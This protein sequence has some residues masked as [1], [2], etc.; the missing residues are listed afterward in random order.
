M[1]QRPDHAPKH[2][3]VHI[4]A[5]DQSTATRQLDL[6]P[7]RNRHAAAGNCRLRRRSSWQRI[8]RND[9][10]HERRRRAGRLVSSPVPAPPGEQQ[11]RINVMAS[12]YNRHR[13]PGL[14]ALRDNPTSLFIGPVAPTSP[15]TR[16]LRYP[17][18]QKCPS[19]LSGHLHSHQLLNF[20]R[21][22][23]SDEYGTL[24]E[25]V[26]LDLENRFIPAHAGN[27]A[28]LGWCQHAGTVHPRACGEHHYCLRLTAAQDGS[29]PRMRGTRPEALRR[30]AVPRFIPAHAGNT[31]R[32]PSSDTM[33]PVHPRACGEH[34]SP[35]T[36]RFC[37]RGSSPRMRGTLQADRY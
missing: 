29:S 12:C 20:T 35:S 1:Q 30:L 15:A 32:F 33:P 11:V 2:R 5:G 22:P 31:M 10:R 8:A 19:S 36:S 25:R 17:C 4:I 23:S 7:A 3:R 21:R 14:E 24:L 37:G 9:C 13:R 26:D 34:R 6:H 18:H 16:R 28:E 27:T